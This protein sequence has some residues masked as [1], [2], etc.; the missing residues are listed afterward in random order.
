MLLIR[1]SGFIGSHALCIRSL[2]F[3]AGVRYVNVTNTLT[4]VTHTLALAMHTVINATLT[5]RRRLL[6]FK[7][8]KVVR[9]SIL[10]PNFSYTI[11]FIRSIK[12]CTHIV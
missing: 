12:R 11:H 3:Y 1:Y 9:I 6:G 8:A 5:D 10:F 7:H 2:L 4:F